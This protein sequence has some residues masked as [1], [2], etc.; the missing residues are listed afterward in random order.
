MNT[1]KLPSEMSWTELMEYRE[2]ILQQQEELE[3]TISVIKD[4]M[5]A[6]LKEEG[7]NGKPVGDKT[8][9]LRVSYTT[10]KDTAKELGAI[11]VVTQERID[12]SMIKALVQKGVTV[13]NLQ[14]IESVMVT[15][16]NRKPKEV[17]AEK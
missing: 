1:Q 17:E 11:K 6:K 4:E 5:L 2:S 14:T 16:I 10:D 8:I 12:V 9:S 7:I 3:A 13:P 15:D